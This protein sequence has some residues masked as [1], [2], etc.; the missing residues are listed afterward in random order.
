MPKPYTFAIR[1]SQRSKQKLQ[2]SMSFA[3]AD[4]QKKT[5]Y[6][7]TTTAIPNTGESANM[8]ENTINKLTVKRKVKCLEIP[9]YT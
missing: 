8:K 4:Y 9:H 5:K 6:D 1:S 3:S 7:R 2:K